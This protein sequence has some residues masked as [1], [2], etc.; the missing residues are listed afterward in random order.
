M[1]CSQRSDAVDRT[2]QLRTYSCDAILIAG[3]DV[4]DFQPITLVEC[5][6]GWFAVENINL[7]TR[8][9]CP[10][11]S[12]TQPYLSCASLVARFWMRFLSQRCNARFRQWVR[13]RRHS[14]HARVIMDGSVAGMKKSL[15]GGIRR[16]NQGSTRVEIGFPNENLCGWKGLRSFPRSDHVLADLGRLMR[17]NRPVSRKPRWSPVP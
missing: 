6:R 10:M 5:T 16:I 4:G 17:S 1:D 13:R 11:D 8:I 2:N 12:S 3:P 9:R 14:R 7:N 15:A